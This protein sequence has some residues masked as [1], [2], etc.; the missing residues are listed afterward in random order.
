LLRSQQ[1]LHPLSF[2]KF[3]LRHLMSTQGA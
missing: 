1:D 3:K 2:Y